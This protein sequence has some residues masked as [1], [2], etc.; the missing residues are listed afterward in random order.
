MGIFD[1]IRP[2]DLLGR[3]DVVSTSTTTSQIISRAPLG[4]ADLARLDRIREGLAAF[5]QDTST[6]AAVGRL[7]DKTIAEWLAIPQKRRPDPEASINNFGVGIGDHLCTALGG[8]WITAVFD[9]GSELVVEVGEGGPLLFPIARVAAQWGSRADWVA[10]YMAECAR[11]VTAPQAEP[12]EASPPPAPAAGPAS[13][14]QVDALAKRALDRAMSLVARGGADLVPFTLEDDETGAVEV[15]QFAGEPV[16]ALE[17]ARRHVRHSAAARAAVGWNGALAVSGQHFSAVLV[18]ASA[19]GE[20]SLLVAQRHQDG[21]AVG[22]P[23]LVARQ[24]PLF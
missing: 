11:E 24:A 18:E 13:S 22:P 8:R 9:N 5:R 4:R 1:R 23:Q 12:G 17:L 6:P 7:M 21:Q 3:P 19:R 14:A 15:T 16:E 20:T 2:Q 10:D